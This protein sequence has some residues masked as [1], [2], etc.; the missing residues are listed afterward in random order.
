MLDHL[1]VTAE[2]LAS[3]V[4]YVENA[5]GV[6]MAPGGQHDYM[7]THNQLLGLGIFYLE[8]ITINPEAPKPSH[9]RWFDLDNISGPP[10]L[11][12]WIV[13]TD[14]LD[15][16]LAK[17]PAGTGTPVKLTRGDLH[18]Q[19]AVPDDGKLPFDGAF[20]ALIQWEGADH[21]ALRLPDLKCRLK[22]LH[23]TH[24]QADGLRDALSV[25][26][27]GDVVSVHQGPA[28][29]LQAEIETLHGIRILE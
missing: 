19:M 10:K 11:T 3:G 24:P 7:G 20:P 12:N 2:N 16:T 29:N 9:P 6:Q 18:W 5:L 22:Q 8:V 13:Q 28:K 14:T 23:V 25:L 21:P 17:S 26:D 4:S 27:F 1:A 15:E